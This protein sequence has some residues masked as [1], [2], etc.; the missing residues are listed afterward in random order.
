[1]SP[2]GEGTPVDR[3]DCVEAQEHW[4]VQGAAEDTPAGRP[5]CVEAQEDWHI[6]EVQKKTMKKKM[7]KPVLEHEQAQLYHKRTRRKST[8]ER[9]LEPLR[10]IAPRRWNNPMDA[11]S[12]PE[13]TPMHLMLHR[14]LHARPRR[15]QD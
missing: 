10:T 14:L 3:P 8:V 11:K 6:Q 13:A 4:H 9:E 1:M 12:R 15:C 2:A 5:A 7:R